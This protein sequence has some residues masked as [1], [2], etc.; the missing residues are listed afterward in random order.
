LN[1]TADYSL[2]KNLTIIF[3]YRHS[4]S[5][6]VVST[7]FPLTNIGSGFTLRYTFGN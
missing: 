7:S 5:K 3:Y 4:F 2:S 6:P 1:V